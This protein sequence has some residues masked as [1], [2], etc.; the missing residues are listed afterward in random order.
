MSSARTV[1]V[2]GQTASDK[3]IAV[4]KGAIV[5]EG[6]DAQ[7]SELDPRQAQVVAAK[8]AKRIAPT[9]A[10]AINDEPIWKSRVLWGALL[11]AIGGT[12]ALFNITGFDA[13]MQSRVLEQIMLWVMIAGLVGGP[14]IT[15]IGRLRGKVVDIEA[16]GGSYQETGPSYPSHDASHE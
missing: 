6:R 1:A 2:T 16:I 14:L 12:L 7:S 15:A 3:I 8:V 9:I 10:N 11:S 4:V 5:D 13:E